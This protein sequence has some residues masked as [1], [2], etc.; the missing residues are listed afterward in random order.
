MKLT[1]MKI[2]VDKLCLC[3]VKILLIISCAFCSSIVK[4]KVPKYSHVVVVIFEN[5]SY[6]QIIG[7]SS[8]SFINSLADSGALFTKFYA[9]VHPSQPNYVILFSGQ[10]MGVT[11][12]FQPKGT[13]F[14]TPNLGAAMIAARLKF[15]GFAEGLPYVGYSGDSSGKYVRKHCPWVNWQALAPNGIDSILSR[16]FSDFPAKFSTLPD[17]CFV[18][19]NLDNDMH[20]GTINAG[21]VWLKK[22]ISAYA[23]WAKKNNSLLVITFDEDNMKEKN[24]IPTIFYGAKV[25]TGKYNDS[26]NHYNLLATFQSMYG[27]KPFGDSAKSKTAAIINCWDTG[28]F[29]IDTTITAIH[30]T[31]PSLDFTIYPN[32]TSGRLYIRGL[33]VSHGKIIIRLF[34][35]KGIL[36][37]SYSNT[38]S[39][40]VSVFSS[41]N[42]IIEI[43]Q[44]GKMARKKVTIEKR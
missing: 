10:Q 32:P 11:D 15:M 20:D 16:P 3:V 8:D 44:M 25:V 2:Q 37:H 22:N 26:L 6:S 17:F 4:A 5:K 13:P 29:V 23:A 18:I 24:R 38:F 12:D 30:K 1:S 40:D 14:S 42:Y 39:L 43:E 9:K 36:V 35:S 21:D 41:G 27:L 28:Q 34:N 7:S 31:V 19:P 33:D